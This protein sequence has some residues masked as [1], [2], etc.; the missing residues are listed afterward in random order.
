MPKRELNI[1]LDREMDNSNM[2]DIIFNSPPPI[3]DKG[4]RS[5]LKK[6]HINGSNCSYYDI[7]P[8][9][10]KG[11]GDKDLLTLPV[12]EEDMESIN[13]NLYNNNNTG[14]QE[15]EGR[16]STVSEQD[17]LDSFDIVLG[18]NSFL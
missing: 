10:I 14:P 18:E 13:L 16:P 12:F 2:E 5:L 3:P 7:A 6:K 4:L 9:E 17:I 1:P 15:V 8:T 11:I